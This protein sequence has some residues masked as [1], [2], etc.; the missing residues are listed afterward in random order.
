[1]Y[2]VMCSSGNHIQVTG[3]F[4]TCQ[5]RVVN[6]AGDVLKEATYK[7]CVAWCEERG[8]EVYMRGLHEDEASTT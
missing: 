6:S 8:I 3:H 2:Q 7:E 5:C 4:R 1:M